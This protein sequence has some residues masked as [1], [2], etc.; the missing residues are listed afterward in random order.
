MAIQ[1]TDRLKFNAISGVKQSGDAVQQ[2]IRK[3]T[4]VFQISTGIYR[5]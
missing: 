1:D 3:G 5:K 2:W 4:A